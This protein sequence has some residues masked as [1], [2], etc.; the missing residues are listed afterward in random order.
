MVVESRRAGREGAGEGRSHPAGRCGGLRAGG[1]RRRPGG[2]RHVLFVVV[3]RRRVLS[4]LVSSFLRC[5]GRS[6]E[7]LQPPCRKRSWIGTTRTEDFSLSGRSYCICVSPLS[8]SQNRPD[9]AS[10]HPGPCR[11]CLWQVLI[12]GPRVPILLLTRKPCSGQIGHPSSFTHRHFALNLQS[13]Q[14]C[15][16]APQ[17]SCSQ[18]TVSLAS[19]RRETVSTF[20]LQTYQ[21]PLYSADSHLRRSFP[22]IAESI[23][24]STSSS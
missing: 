16:S 21:P 4:C 11:F 23:P 1:R 19:T 5:R 7:G 20:H 18:I 22:S 2:G 10:F 9:T 12:Q 8:A 17:D 24:T 13:H 15:H 3:R 6:E 14:D